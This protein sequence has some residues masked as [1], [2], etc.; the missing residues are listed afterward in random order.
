MSAVPKDRKGPRLIC[1]EPMANQWMQQAIRRWL[2]DSVKRT[3]LGRSID[4]RSQEK[5]RHAALQGSASASFATLDLSEAS[6]RLSY[7]LVKLVFEVHLS[8]WDA[9]DAVRTKVVE[10]SISYQSPRQ[11]RLSKFSTMGS[12]L[13]FPVQS[14][15]FTLL[16][17]WALR[18]TEGREHDWRNWR[19]DFDRVRVFGDDLIVPNHAYEVTCQVLHLAGLRVNIRKS[20]NGKYFR[21]SCGC[22]AFKGVDVTP[23]RLRKAYDGTGSSTA[24]LVEFSNNLFLK[25]FWRAADKMTDLLPPAVK[26]GL[27]V[28]GPGEPVLGLVSFSKSWEPKRKRWDPDYQRWYAVRIAFSSK[29]RRTSTDGT[30]RLLQYFTEDPASQRD[31]RD[32]IFW[33]PG[34]PMVDR[35]RICRS[36]VYL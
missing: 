18:L 2:E 28:S 20:F 16:C 22:D 17:V 4:F 21:E 1:A 19:A 15:V 9:F 27:W 3:T 35:L 23:P 6:D 33:E 34:Q 25:G 30:P 5:S 7:L 31:R 13:T 36:R 11:I 8:L 10:Q 12:A 32:V 26:N 29:V 24:S 14:I